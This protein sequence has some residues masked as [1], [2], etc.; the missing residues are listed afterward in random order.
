MTVASSIEVITP[1]KA[2]GWLEANTFVNRRVRDTHVKMI[3]SEIREGR[4]KLNGEAI[5]FDPQGNLLDGQHR[6]W[7]IIEANRAVSSVVVRNITPDAFATLDSG[8]KRTA[9]DVLSASGIKNGM[10]AAAAIKLVHFVMSNDHNILN[11]MSNAETLALMDRYVGIEEAST[12]VC[13]TTQARRIMAGTPLAATM[14]FA[15]QVDRDKALDFLSG[16]SSGEG[17]LRG[18][19]RLTCRTYFLS[20]RGTHRIKNYIQL[21]LLIKT[22][23]AFLQDRELHVLKFGAAE[24][25][26]IPM[27]IVPHRRRAA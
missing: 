18:D 13:N 23:N 24:P 3:A 21:A 6:L 16:I 5:V 2:Q 22:W 10:S 11:K 9:G 19:P 14:Y 26:P 8:V 27:G 17:L 25:Y 7:A 12:L 1:E 15:L 20:R 4:W